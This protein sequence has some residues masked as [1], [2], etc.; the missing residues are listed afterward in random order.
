MIF[1]TPLPPGCWGVWV[2]GGVE[3]FGL[4]LPLC[5]GSD[6]GSIV[7]V[8]SKTNTTIIHDYYTQF[9]EH[10]P[11]FTTS[12]TVINEEFCGD[13]FFVFAH[14]SPELTILAKCSYL[15]GFRSPP[16]FVTATPMSKLQ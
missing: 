9:G 12:S 15:P 10:L 16:P 1:L 13:V 11:N 4:K 14:W 3:N 8:L 6:P 2:G 5:V 7:H